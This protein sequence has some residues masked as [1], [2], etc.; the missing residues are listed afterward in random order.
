[1][2]RLLK[3]FLSLTLIV[4]GLIGCDKAA[5]ARPTSIA[6]PSSATT[7]SWII[8]PHAVPTVAWR[9]IASTLFV[10]AD[11][12]ANAGSL[13]AESAGVAA[14][15]APAAPSNLAAAVNGSQVR[16]T[17][18]APSG[19]DAPASYIV[20]AGSSSGLADLANF[21]T[22]SAALG[23]TADAVP[24]GRYLVR[25]RARNS[26]GT[27]APSNEA[28]VTVEAAGCTAVPGAPTNLAVTVTGSSLRLTW[29]APP[30]G[31]APGSY[32]LEAGSSS[33]SSNV[34]TVNTGNTS[35]SFTAS[36][37]GSGVYYIRVR[38]VGAG[39]T[40][41]ASNEVIAS[42]DACT[43]AP[44][45]PTNLNQ[46][47]A[48]RTFT[49][50]WGAASGTPTSYI[51]EG[52]S[53]S[54][55]ADLLNSDSGNTTTSFSATTDPGT[56]YLRIRA[57]NA[58]GTSPASNQAIVTIYGWSIAFRPLLA[59]LPISQCGIVAPGGLCSQQFTPR[60]AAGEFH[61]VWSPMTPALQVD[62]TITASLV[63]V[64]LRCT[65][66]ASSGSFSGNWDGSKYV[67]TWVMGNS[68]GTIRVEQG[69]V[70]TQC[71]VP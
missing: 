29:I 1:M 60:G 46:S 28:T 22:G 35:T 45:P 24:A 37:V 27:S 6:P 32:L 52:G 57:R 31:C 30:T 39:G 19:G 50:T 48:N 71:Q 21:D 34:A 23:L 17:W 13:R 67:G 54:G 58:C 20:E 61:E 16:L 10:S 42:I 69:S 43:A 7:S 38:A 2:C 62:G 18:S 25:V 8:E 47:V 9:C 49:L 40:S 55:L 4:V 15:V 11:C 5:P 53:Q 65:N 14:A 26:G 56:Y 70:D 51:I 41:A 64:T 63:S 3:G 68:S 59:G 66:G 44:G 36:S 33:G 12:A